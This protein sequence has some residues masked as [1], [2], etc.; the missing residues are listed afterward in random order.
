ML[1]SESALASVI[2][3]TNL[4]LGCTRDEIAAFSEEALVYR[5]HSVCVLAN[6]V[7]Y[8]RR[9]VAGTA[10]AVAA[11]VSFPLG[12]DMA[13]TKAFE[14][15]EAQEMGAT[16]ID[17]VI[18]TGRARALDSGYLASEVAAVRA[19]M[20]SRHVL[21]VIIEM[22]LLDREQAIAAARAA[23]SGG[24]DLVKTSTGFKGLKIRA[25]LPEDVALLRS[26]L[27][28]ETGIKAAGGIRSLDDLEALV[29]LGATRIGTSSGVAIMEA[30]RKRSG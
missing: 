8:A 5:F 20:P 10:T 22:P 21:K 30:Y 24:A 18:H 28:P 23:E 16:E 12:M 1:D 3:Q 11:C 29:E 19:V 15:R 2:D 14:A 13:G 7:P 25:T 27:R 26:V 4:T 17:M 9:V 6:M